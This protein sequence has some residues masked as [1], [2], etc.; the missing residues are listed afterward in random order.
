M[1]ADLNQRRGQKTGSRQNKTC[2]R[3]WPS[4]MSLRQ[5][6]GQRAFAFCLL[7][8][9]KS[10]F[11]FSDQLQKEKKKQFH[12]LTFCCVCGFVGNCPGNVRI[13]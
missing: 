10:D 9:M 8:S 1:R 12:V 7:R 11:F 13:N 5:L 4:V 6:L 2:G 3:S